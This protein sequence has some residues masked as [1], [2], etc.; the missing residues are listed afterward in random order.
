M[1]TEG[2]FNCS[3]GIERFLCHGKS[4]DLRTSLRDG[5]WRMEDGSEVMNQGRRQRS[6]CHAYSRR[7]AGGN[8]NLLLFASVLLLLLGRSSHPTY[9]P[10]GKS[11][12][13]LGKNGLFC[14][15]GLG[16]FSRSLWNWS[17]WQIELL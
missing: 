7:F 17:W 16:P 14:A 2:S 13:L 5:G 10:S 9:P 1:V 12:T 15:L 6:I 4:V 3:R 8:E 11:H